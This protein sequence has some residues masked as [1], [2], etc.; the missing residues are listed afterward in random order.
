MRTRKSARE[1]EL[2]LKTSV[3]VVYKR[4]GAREREIERRE[5]AKESEEERAP[6][7]NRN[8]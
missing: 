1:L 7:L 5:Y 4:V 6:I 8:S 3:L 2:C